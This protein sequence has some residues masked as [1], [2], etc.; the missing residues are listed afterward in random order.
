MQ[1]GIFTYA[2]DLDAEGYD[3]A[4]GRIAD[5]GFNAINLACAYHAGKFLLPRNP[6]HRVYFPEDG[7]VYFEPD[8][9][10]YGRIKPRV[11]SLVGS[12]GDPLRTLDNACQKRGIDL[13]AWTVCLHNTWLGEHFPDC[14]VHNAFGDPIL[15][16]ISPAHP[17]IREYMTAVLTDIVSNANVRA[18]QLES[19][20]YMGYE[21]GFHHEVL[22]V[23]LD[24]MQRLLLG[25]SFNPVEME[26]AGNEG[27]DTEALRRQVA[28]TLDVSWNE[29]ESTQRMVDQLLANPDFESYGALL[30]LIE[31]EFIEELRNAV[32]QTRDGVEVRLFA[33]MAASDNS[34]PLPAHIT[35]LADGLLTGYV[36]SD[37]AARTRARQ[38]KEIMDDKP[39]YGMV[40]AISPDAK[41]PEDA[42]SRIRSWREAGA[43]G[44]DVY[45]YGF[46]PAPMIQAVGKALTS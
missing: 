10:R 1:A 22:P 30:S 28:D 19:P 5:A 7:A 38:L 11:S 2:W 42:A 45:N 15:H 34:R 6:R 37:V 16:S 21:H 43:D 41:E 44:V 9:S 24:D 29:P 35:E 46:M 14:T 4:V 12:T 33:G 26:R 13:V 32:R 8:R 3:T 36:A 27:I 40:R 31:A 20:E 39:V 17:D 23:T 25:L 18:V